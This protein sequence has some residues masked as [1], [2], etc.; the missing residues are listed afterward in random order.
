M[1]AAPKVKDA[2][3][4]GIEVVKGPHTGLRLSFANGTAT[5]GRGPENDIVLANDPRISRQH[6]EIRQRGS[7]FLIVNLS[8][9]NFVMLNGESVQSEILQKGSVIQIGDSEI[10]FLPETVA[11][12][13]PAIPVM[14]SAGAVPAAPTLRPVSPSGMPNMPAAGIPNMPAAKPSMPPGGVRPQ[15]PMGQPQGAGYQQQA[16]RPAPRSP[17]GGGPLS[18]PRVRFYGIIAIV[19]IAGYFFFAGPNKAAKDPNAFRS[20]AI[21]MKDV[22][23]AEKRTQELMNIKKEKYDSVQY[24]R[25]QENF[26]RGFRD[27]QQGQ[28]ARAREAF[29]V[30]L[31]L[32]P[33]NELAKRYYH[34]SKIKF[35]ELVKFNLIQGSR[36]REKKNWRMCQSNYSNVITMLQ[37]RRDDPSYKEAKQFYEECTLNQEGGRL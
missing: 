33:E 5:I 23:E 12:A 27:F 17:A 7:E 32:D 24:K 21:S 15:M 37:N 22:Q 28:Y 2:L 20:S 34:L 36:Y 4:F 1:S 19:G 29:Q 16:P 25:A 30:V 11:A 3:K 18:N 26:I 35:D 8:Q 10:R 14:P 31:N 9:K 6:A 13:E